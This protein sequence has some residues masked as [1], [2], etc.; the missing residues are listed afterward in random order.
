VFL[1]L[2]LEVQPVLETKS[3]AA[4]YG[5]T[6]ALFDVS[7]RV[8]P[9]QVLALVGTNGAG[10]TTTVRAIM[11]LIRSTGAVTVNGTDISGWPTHRRAREARIAVVHESVNLFGELT[12]IEN[13]L[14]GLG[15]VSRERLEEVQAI[16]PIIAERPKAPVGTLSGGQRQMVALGKAFLSDPSYLLL[17]EPSLGLSPAMV[18]VIYQTITEFTARNVGVLLIEQNISRAADV[19]TEIQLVSIGRSNPA[20]QASDRQKVDQLQQLAFGEM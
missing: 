9:G 5:P 17:D 12:I 16:F 8:T 19:A 10:K 3:L 13:L 15:N 1:I 6:Q 18:E 7:V 20:I 11:G 2:T 4:W 14:L